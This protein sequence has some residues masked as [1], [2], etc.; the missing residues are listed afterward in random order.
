MHNRMTDDMDMDA[1]VILDGVPVADVGKQI[2]EKI[3]SI[4]S[5][6]K[7]KSEL[8]GFGELE[9]APWTLGPVM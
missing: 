3:I 6:E 8:Q 2:F 1:G 4:A 9:F 5:G 7:T